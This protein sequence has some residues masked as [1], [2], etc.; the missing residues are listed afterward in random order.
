MV[1][2]K[3]G[4]MQFAA[5]MKGFAFERALMEEHFNEN[6]VESDKFPK[7]E[8]KGEL[9]NIDKIDF[10]K[11]GTYTAKVKGK[12]TMHGESNEVETDAKIII[13]NGKIKATAELN[14]L[15]VRL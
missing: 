8:F 9:K 5:L 15:L 10:T 7:A 11:D 14:V 4:N 13:Q 1:D 2:T 12:L 3:T 6:Y